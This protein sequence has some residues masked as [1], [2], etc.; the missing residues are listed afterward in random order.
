MKK[1]L[2]LILIVLICTISFGQ[3]NDQNQ[4]ITRKGFIGLGLGFNIPI[5]N[6]AK[7]TD[8][9]AKTGAQLTLINFGYLFSDRIGLTATWFGASNPIAGVSSIYMWSYGGI[10]AGPLFSFPLSKKIE[11]DIKPMI[12]ISWA[13]ILNTNLPVSYSLGLNIGTGLRFNIS[14]LIALT[15]D[16]DYKIGN[17]QWSIGHQTI[18]T[19][20]VK[21]GLV[22]RLK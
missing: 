9:G 20:G 7:I 12:G 10:L 15:L 4:S 1:N 14:R 3:T 6:Y 11:W 22:F 8:G 16:V 18:S 17:Y 13:S 5:G 19:I 21:G 2:A